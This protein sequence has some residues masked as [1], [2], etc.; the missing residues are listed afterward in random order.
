MSEDS[1]ID[2]FISYAREDWE[3]AEQLLN[4]FKS[5]GW[6]VWIDRESISAG[7]IYDETI[8][9]ALNE[10]RCVI[11]IWSKYSVSKPWVK[12]EAN[13]GLKNE[14]LVPVK[15]DAVEL[16]L[17]FDR[18]QTADLT[19][20]DG[21]PTFPNLQKLIGDIT[22]MLRKVGK[23]NK[24]GATH[25]TTPGNKSNHRYKFKVFLLGATAVG[26]TSVTRRFVSRDFPEEYVTTLGVQVHEAICG[27]AILDI[28]DLEGADPFTDL[29]PDY[30]AGSDGCLLVVDGTRKTTLTEA[31]AIHKEASETTGTIP[32]IVLIN[33]CDLMDQ[34]EIG[35]SDL[36]KIARQDLPFINTSAKNNENINEAFHQLTSKI[37]QKIRQS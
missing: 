37:M 17:P 13:E 16:P 3:R 29:R 15:I 2:I 19:V 28:L 12:S 10:A 4:T 35:E 36:K 32:C 20:C 24:E 7:E 1:A 31:L 34:W 23:E 21:H 9:N 5:H 25:E 33:K 11:V 30:Y 6:S 8:S 27:P 26:K 14:K 18:I 22:T